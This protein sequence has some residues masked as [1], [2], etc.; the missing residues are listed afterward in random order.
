MDTRWLEDAII[1]LEEEN[2][3]RAAARR[4]VTQPA[5]SRRIRALEEWAGI[6]LLDR[7]ANRV[8]INRVLI[9]NSEEI[10]STISKIENLKRLLKSGDAPKRLHFA[11]Q[12]ALA[13]SVFPSLQGRLSQKIPAM[14]WRLR[15]VNRE[16][17]V[18]LFLRGEADVLMIYEARGFPPLPFDASVS[19]HTWMHDNLIPVCGGAMRNRLGSDLNNKE[20]LP[21]IKYPPKSHFGRLLERSGLEDRLYEFETSIIVESAF[22]SAVLEMVRNSVGM[23]WVPH[24]MCHRDIRSGRLVNLSGLLGHIPL[25]ITLFSS[26]TNL[27]ATSFLED[28]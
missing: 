4:N 24:S 27:N 23:G 17:C 8:E 25:S 21:L 18:S 16:E 12:H 10:K 2:L 13:V 5:F 6:E 3:S 9:N 11:T 7:S 14:S 15:T 26:S 28:L 20:P 19:R 1:L 22:T